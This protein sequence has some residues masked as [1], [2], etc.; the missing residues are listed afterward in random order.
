MISRNPLKFGLM[1]TIQS[2]KKMA[3]LAT[4]LRSEGKSIAFVPTM[5]YFHEG[6]LSLMRHGRSVCDVLVV[7]IF[8]N[9]LQF[10]PGEDFGRYPRDIRRDAGM[11]GSSSADV[12]FCPS[13]D[14]M[15]PAGFQTHIEVE[16]VTQSLCGGKRPGHFR[17]VTTVVAKLINI[18]RPQKAI[19]GLK[20]YQQWLTVRRMAA[21]LNMDVEVVGRPTTREPD[22]LAMSSR[23]TYLAPEERQTALTVY[24]SLRLAN[25]LIS[26]GERDAGR[27]L[28]AVCNLLSSQGRIDVE[29]VTICDPETLSERAVID[30][31]TLLA[32]AVRIGK[33]RLIDNCFLFSEKN[34]V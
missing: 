34:N 25:D 27:I 17:G 11:A 9:P 18:V 29:Y 24:Q 20:D 8:V 30:G 3:A 1:R 7:S 28:K 12:L 2:V 15:Y 33:T 23:N 6:H 22:G 4:R 32:V 26:K 31:K 13:A 14:E 10:G 16:A 21:D 19:F 5:G